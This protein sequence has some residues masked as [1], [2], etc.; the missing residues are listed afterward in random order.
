MQQN[1]YVFSGNRQGLENAI[2]YIDFKHV[3]T[4]YLG[5]APMG[6]SQGTPGAVIWFSGKPF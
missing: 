6:A 4:I 5:T 3:I 1:T 2:S